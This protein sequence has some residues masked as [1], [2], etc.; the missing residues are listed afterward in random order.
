MIKLYITISALLLANYLMAQNKVVNVEYEVYF[1]TEIPNAQK[2]N[3][4]FEQSK[5][6][7]IYKKNNSQKNDA[8]S[9]RNNEENSVSLKLLRSPNINFYVL[10]K[11]VALFPPKDD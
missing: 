10:N 8:K 3:L 6:T 1:N 9:K 5:N 2:A 4:Y 11:F 7:S